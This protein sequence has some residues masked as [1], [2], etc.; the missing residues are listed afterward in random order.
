MDELMCDWKNYKI[1]KQT[2]E[3]KLAC[4]IRDKIKKIEDY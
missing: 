3:D 4:Y 2:V 1:M